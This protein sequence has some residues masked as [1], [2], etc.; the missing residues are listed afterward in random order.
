MSYEPENNM[1]HGFIYCIT[2]NVNGKMYIGQ[3][4]TTVQNRWKGHRVSS[5]KS[6]TALYRAMRKYG[7]ENFSVE[8]IFAIADPDEEKIKQSLNF[9]EIYF[10][11]KYDTLCGNNGYNLTKGGDTPCI[12]NITP[13]NQY[14]LH[15]N[16]IKHYDS[17][18]EASIQTGINE[19]AIRQNLNH[20]V[21]MVG[22][23]IFCRI[24]E[25]PV[26]PV[27][28]VKNN[29]D[30][31]NVDISQYSAD[32]LYKLMIYGWNGKKVI[33]YNVYGELVNVFRDPYEAACALNI[34]SEDIRKYFSRQI[35]ENGGKYFNNT[36]LKYEGDEFTE[37]DLYEEIKPVS[38]YDLIGNFVM[39][40]PNKYEAEKYFGICEG[41]VGKAIRRG[42]SCKSHLFSYYNKPIVRK[43][44]CRDL[45]IEML[46]EN[47]NVIKEFPTMKSVATYYNL[48][49]CYKSIRKA[50]KDSSLW[51]G[52]YWKYKDGVKLD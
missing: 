44:R 7:I 50:I 31:T 20:Y 37:D 34:P 5:K 29:Y 3:T 43:I 2:N 33:Q 8:T 22:R 12:F 27:Y 6:D 10:I 26:L 25:I 18:Q 24:D 4:R 13:V 23:Y 51:K 21:Q 32:E 14:D 41:N 15:L 45:A 46:D 17:V 28:S 9:L 48:T 36:I 16:L 30:F 47:K 38:A 42:G 40:F 19:N 39:R 52:F 1:Y 35:E 49:D 11:A